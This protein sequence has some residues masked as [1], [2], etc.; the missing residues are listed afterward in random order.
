MDAYSAGV[1]AILLALLPGLAEAQEAPERGITQV[2]GDL[3]RWQNGAHY[4]VV[5]VTAAGLIVGDTVNAEASAWLAGQIAQRWDLPVRYVVYS[6]HHADHASGGSAFEATATFVGHRNSVAH[7][8]QGGY[9]PVPTVT[10]EDRKEV[11]LGGKTVDLIYP[12][13][14][15]SD[16]LIV[17]HFPAE[18]ALFV[19]DVASVERLPYRNFPGFFFA[20]AFDSFKTMEAIDF[21]IFVGGH[22][23]IGTKQDMLDHFDY[24]RKLYA[25][26]EQAVEQG[27]TLEAAQEKISMDDYAEWGRY[28][29]WRALN[30]AGVYNYLTSD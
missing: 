23:N 21:D 16:S 7:F 18:R 25:E 27:L 29:E 11:T 1:T 30:V 4:G 13:P 10:F 14:S 19:V 20:Q 5:Y 12:G 3:Y 9:A 26:V 24:V 22:G 17:M 15:H 8:E 2:S 6:H 28:E